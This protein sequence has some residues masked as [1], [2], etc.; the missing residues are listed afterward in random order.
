MLDIA[1]RRV[2][3]ARDTLWHGF[4]WRIARKLGAPAVAFLPVNG[5]VA[6]FP[7][8]RASPIAAAMTPEQVVAAAA[9][10]G[11]GSLVPIHYGEFHNPPVYVETPDVL[12]RLKVAAHD[13]GVSVAMTEPGEEVVL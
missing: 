8:M 1:G 5:A 13:S 4:W 6:A 3:H 11:A 12:R 2:F 9:V 7:G 10:L